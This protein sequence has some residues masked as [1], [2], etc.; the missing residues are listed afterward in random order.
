M[1]KQELCQSCFYKNDCQ[2][3]YEH[4]GKAEGPAIAWKAVTAFLIPL[5]VF[6][7]GLSVFEW[8]WD[9]LLENKEFQTAISFLLA[10]FVTA[11]LILTI[12]K[13]SKKFNKDE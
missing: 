2:K 4:L 12:K 5:L 6:I 8:I 7:T 3:V 10:L 11:V 13:T 1:V 9:D